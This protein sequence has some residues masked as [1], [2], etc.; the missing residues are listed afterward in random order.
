MR[1]TGDILKKM[2]KQRKMNQQQLCKG[3]ISRQAYSRLENNLQE[4]NYEILLQ[5][6]NRLN[7]ETTDFWRELNHDNPLDQ[8][9]KL[10]L[11]GI[12]GEMTEKEAAELMSQLNSITEKNN[13]YYHLLGMIS[14]HLHSKFP[15]IIPDLKEHI[16]PY[17]KNYI[18]D[19]TDLSLYDL[20][21]IGDFATS[22][23]SYP[24][25]KEFFQKLDEFDPY[26]YGEESYAYRTQIHKIYNNFCDFALSK[27]DLQFAKTIL[28]RH[29]RFAKVHKDL[30][31]LSYLQI[32]NAI[33]AYR[34]TGDK[35]HL[36]TLKEI[37]QALETCGDSNVAKKIDYQYQAYKTEKYDP[38]KAISY[39]G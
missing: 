38:S 4:P 9:H 31:Y 8:C 2:R 25:Q 30:R 26:A 3:I 5:L 21:I 36:E 1:K 7:Y 18:Q 39:D 33:Y 32:N 19:L 13:R 34:I 27:N 35:K 22:A 23:L 6:L 28:D 24:E 10:Y 37:A 29:N 17:F 14:G 15:K 11:K 12:A 20:R 16:S